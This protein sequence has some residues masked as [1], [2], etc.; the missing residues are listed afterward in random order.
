MEAPGCRRRQL[1]VLLL[2]GKW[3]GA[4]KGAP[5]ACGGARRYRPRTPAAA[6]RGAAGTGPA[7]SRRV[8][9]PHRQGFLP[10]HGGEVRERCDTAHPPPPLCKSVPPGGGFSPGVPGGGHP[11]RR[12]AGPCGWVWRGC[13]GCSPCGALPPSLPPSRAER[14]RFG[15]AGRAGQH[16]RRWSR[17]ASSCRLPTA[18]GEPRNTG[19]GAQPPGETI[20]PTSSLSQAFHLGSQTDTGEAG[21]AV[22]E[23]SLLQARG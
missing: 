7:S 17:P 10:G 9:G 1:P 5:A 21:L 6:P 16:P 11:G 18:G 12:Q 2:W 20:S 14:E 13:G 23:G 22:G 4:G 8:R 15:G 3:R 19:R